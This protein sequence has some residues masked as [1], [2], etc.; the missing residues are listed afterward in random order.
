MEIAPRQSPVSLRYPDAAAC[1]R[2]VA[3]LAAAGIR[4]SVEA[5]GRALLA[6]SG[7][8]TPRDYLPL[9]AAEPDVPWEKVWVTLTDERFV[10][11]DHAESNG[12]LARALLV[13]RVG[14]SSRWLPLVTHEPS[15]GGTPLSAV[16][17]AEAR[18]RAAG[19]TTPDVT[20]LGVGFDGHIASVFP[21][22]PAV[23][24]A[25]RLQFTDG[26]PGVARRV[27]WS[28]DALAASPLVVLPVVGAAKI[29]ALTPEDEPARRP[30]DLLRARACGSFLVLA[31]PADG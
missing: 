12:Q 27:T 20:L 19:F 28:L 21:D 26:A 13:D 15:T 16:S 14:C 30:V 5:R 22:R 6:C 29:A 2:A 8:N 17:A 11:P 24:A 10:S 18:I 31:A 9:L 4:A 1:A 7:G 3:S 25:G 23:P